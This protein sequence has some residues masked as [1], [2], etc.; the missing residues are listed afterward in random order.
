MSK[1]FVIGLSGESI[2][3]KVN[4]FHKPG[5]TLHADSLNS[6][7]GGKGYN[8]A[9]AL[10]KFGSNVSYLSSVGKDL[11]GDK[12]EKYLLEKGI[13]AFM[14]KKDTPTALATILTNDLGDNQVTVFTGATNLLDEEDVLKV[15][16]EIA[17]S[18]YLLLQLEVPLKANLKAVEIAKKNNVKIVINPAPAKN[19]TLEFLQSADI[20]TPNEEEAKTIFNIN[21]LEEI[22]EKMIELKIKEVIVT[23][24]SEGALHFKN[25][26]I[27]KFP[28]LK[29]EAIDTTGAG[30]TFNAMLVYKL[31]NGYS[32]DES[33]KWANVAA[34]LSATKRGVMEAIP[35]IDEI[36]KTC[37]KI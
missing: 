1:V 3:L 26:N 34:S 10:K 7:C 15:E 4:H 18:N 6:E 8:Q 5:E 32:V 20:I 24:G 31:S 2:F 29:V 17:S 22:K 19:Y 14:I 35:S 33:I 25:G 11:Y 12:C 36:K 27:N 30:D 28:T 21:N 23:C 9:V 16:N 13:N 37:E